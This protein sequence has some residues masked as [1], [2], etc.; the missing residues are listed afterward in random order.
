M[1][2][3]KNSPA[4]MSAVRQT[5]GIMRPTRPNQC[6]T[7]LIMRQQK[8][9]TRYM[10]VFLHHLPHLTR[11]AKLSSSDS[12]SPKDTQPMKAKI[13]TICIMAAYPLGI[14][15]NSTSPITNMSSMHAH[16]TAAA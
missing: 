9:S 13:K 8:R 12:T 7:A 4:I 6:Q 1:N 5:M 2:A 15:Q 14:F 10:M 3:I 11:V 16:T